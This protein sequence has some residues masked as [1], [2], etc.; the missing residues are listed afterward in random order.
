MVNLHK[1]LSTWQSAVSV[2][3][4]PSEFVRKQYAAAGFSTKN[5]VV[6]PHFVFPDPGMSSEHKGY[7]LF[8]GRLCP[9]KG[10]ETL[11]SSWKLLG[12][13]AILK[14]V[15]DGPERSRL[16]SLARNQ[17][18]IEFLGQLPKERV[19]Q[20]LQN[21]HFTIVPS[22]SEESF[23]LGVIEAFACGVPVIAS[24]IGAIPELVDPERTGFLFTPGDT[25]DLAEKLD[26][27]ITNPTMRDFRLRCREEYLGKYTADRNIVMLNDIY[28]KAMAKS[29]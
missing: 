22:E 7:G 23:G 20:L 14:I 16:Q 26:R 17:P 11:I 24:R 28:A 15:G 21:A 27:M 3:I 12:S 10:V 4:A 8:V 6:K 13:S 5:M 9:E 25:A 19:L 18:R 2:Y 1:I 29:L